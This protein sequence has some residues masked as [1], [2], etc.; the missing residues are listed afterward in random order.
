VAGSA[1]VLAER[2]RVACS[3]EFEGRRTRCI[4]SAHEWATSH[5]SSSNSTVVSVAFSDDRAVCPF[6]SASR[7][8][9]HTELLAMHNDRPMH[10]SMAGSECHARYLS[11]ALLSVY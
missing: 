7:I 3:H 2:K 1:T 4:R 10:Q 8:A 9:M 11:T 6:A 5:S